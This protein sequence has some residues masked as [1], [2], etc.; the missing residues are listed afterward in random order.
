[1]T[2]ASR[3]VRSVSFA[4]I[5]GLSLGVSAPG[6]LAMETTVLAQG[7]PAGQGSQANKANID[8]TKTG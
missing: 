7:A 3:T 6:A 4:A 5:L 1:M 2:V 8:F